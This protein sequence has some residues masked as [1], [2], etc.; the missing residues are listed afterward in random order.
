MEAKETVLL[1]YFVGVR[2][3]IKLTLL[4]GAI[5]VL[6]RKLVILDAKHVLN[7]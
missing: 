7:E 5:V 6:Q 2:R 3:E 4:D 1:Q